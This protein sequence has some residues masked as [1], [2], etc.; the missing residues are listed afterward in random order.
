MLTTTT[1]IPPPPLPI[2][3]SAPAGCLRS[4]C[5]YERST[6]STTLQSFGSVVTFVDCATSP[7]SET[8]GALQPKNPPSPSMID[9]AER[10]N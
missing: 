2:A 4:G 8:A 3:R 6:A 9:D 5:E 10:Q 1:L 7:V